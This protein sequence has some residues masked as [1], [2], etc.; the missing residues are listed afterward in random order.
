[1]DLVIPTR[2]E[3]GAAVST[4][5][6]TPD[7]APAPNLYT[8]TQ[9]L[10]ITAFGH[11]AFREVI[12]VKCLDQG[13]IYKAVALRKR[14]KDSFHPS[15]EDTERS[16]PPQRVFSAKA[17]QSSTLILDFWASRTV[18]KDIPAV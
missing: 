16:W 18:R 2:S 8:Q 5:P 7:P 17:H 11:G 4:L 14:G 6:S 9:T 10:N 15:S 12:K 1:M 3:A 13:G